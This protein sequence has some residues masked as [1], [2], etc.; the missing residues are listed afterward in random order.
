MHSYALCF[1]SLLHLFIWYVFICIPVTE[2]TDIRGQFEGPRDR[3]QPSQQ[4]PLWQAILMA[5]YLYFLKHFYIRESEGDSERIRYLG[6]SVV[7]SRDQAQ[8]VLQA[9]CTA[10]L[11]TQL[12]QALYSFNCVLVCRRNLLFGPL[13]FF[14]FALSPL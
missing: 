5:P 8:V 4:A 9:W 1:T 11:P 6:E 2:C 13:S 14:F 3:I 7:A 10:P 12:S